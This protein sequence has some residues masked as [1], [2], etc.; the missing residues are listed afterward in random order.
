MT[1]KY[2]K[3]V[4]YLGLMDKDNLDY[5]F[6]ADE[7]IDKITQIIGECTIKNCFGFYK[8]KSQK[9]LKIDSLEITKYTKSLPDNYIENTTKKLKEIFNQTSILTEITKDCEVSFNK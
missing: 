6:S 8:T 4:F 9:L 1:D 7:A 3:I 5:K 2:I